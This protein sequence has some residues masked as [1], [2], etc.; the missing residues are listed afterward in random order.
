M[1]GE[2]AE[3]SMGLCKIPTPSRVAAFPFTAPPH[4]SHISHPFSLGL[5]ILGEEGRA[6]QDL[7]AASKMLSGGVVGMAKAQQDSASPKAAVGKACHPEAQQPLEPPHPPHRRQAVQSSESP[8]TTHGDGKSP[9]TSP[10]VAPVL[11]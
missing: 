2:E 6:K 8:G 4:Y 10:S 9:C 3:A 1:V 5:D 7:P 11:P